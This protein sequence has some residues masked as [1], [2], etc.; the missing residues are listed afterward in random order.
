MSELRLRLAQGLLG[1]LGAFQR[2]DIGAGA[3]IAEEMALNVKK[4]LSA[5]SDIN[6]GSA[7]VDDAVDEIPKRPVGIKCLAMPPPFFRLGLQ[8]GC[9]LPSRHPGQAGA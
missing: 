3:A 5:G 7:V 9:D 4:G 6:L 1:L 2:G 8:I